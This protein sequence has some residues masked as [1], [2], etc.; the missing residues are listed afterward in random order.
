MRTEKFPWWKLIVG[1]LFF[2]LHHQ[3]FDLLGGN[4]LGVIL[5]EGIEVVSRT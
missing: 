3:I 1:Y 5:G 2:I 4:V